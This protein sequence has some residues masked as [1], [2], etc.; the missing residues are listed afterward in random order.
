MPQPDQGQGSLL[1]LLVL[2]GILSTAVAFSQK[3][4]A[5]ASS[6]QDKAAFEAVCGACH[7]SNLDNDLR[8]EGEW[9]ETIEKM[10]SLG[11]KGT[12]DQFDALLRFLL[13]TRTKVNVNS[14]PASEIAPVLDISK[15]AAEAVVKRRTE[16]GNFKSLDELKKV[17]GVDATKLDARRD[18]IRFQ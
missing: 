3:E 17:P 18:R 8:T 16:K 5:D 2:A 12:D 7:P 13:Q 10:A 1:G 11:A 6:A 4:P 14:A 15:S 9:N